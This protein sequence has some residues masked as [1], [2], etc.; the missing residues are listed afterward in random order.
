M[1]DSARFSSDEP[2]PQPGGMV[3]SRPQSDHLSLTGRAGQ[4]VVAYRSEFLHLWLL[5]APD[6][7]VPE[8]LADLERA[9]LDVPPGAMA[10]PG[11]AL[12]LE[13]Q[14]ALSGLQFLHDVVWDRM[15]IAGL[16]FF[17]G[18]VW[19]LHT[20]LDA[21]LEQMTGAPVRWRWH[22]WEGGAPLAYVELAA[23]EVWR[24]TLPHVDGGLD[25]HYR[26]ALREVVPT[27]ADAF[28]AAAQAPRESRRAR[29]RRHRQQPLSVAPPAPAPPS[30]PAVAPVPSKPARVPAPPR[31]RRHAS[32]AGPAGVV[33]ASS[34]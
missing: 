11:V 30:P 8:V 26:P 15:G 22:E 13:V 25:A 28:A 7:S 20:M 24:L 12:P 9:A 5:G 4:G 14:H 34:R 16:V 3:A 1:N 32:R 10:P 29:R 27:E 2:A 31:H 21:S 33:I 17:Q 6:A 23:G 19:A 18:R